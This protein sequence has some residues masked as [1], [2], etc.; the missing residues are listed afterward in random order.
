[1]TDKPPPA[2][3]DSYGFDDAW[4]ESLRWAQRERT[5]IIQQREYERIPFG[6]DCAGKAS[7]LPTCRDCGTAHGELH[8][9]TCCWEECPRCGGQ[10]ISCDCHHAD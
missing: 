9:P 4:A 5:Y 6:E 2:D 3:H 8:V 10:A 1:M 7:Q